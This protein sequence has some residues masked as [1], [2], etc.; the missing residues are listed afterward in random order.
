MA[1]ASGHPAWALETLDRQ[2]AQDVTPVVFEQ[3]DLEL[4]VERVK[5]QIATVNEAVAKIKEAEKLQARADEARAS[6][7]K[8]LRP[9]I[10]TAATILDGS[11]AI[12][13]PEYKRR[14]VT[15]GD[16]LVTESEAAVNL[17]ALHPYTASSHNPVRTTIEASRKLQK[18]VR[19]TGKNLEAFFTEN[20]AR[21]SAHNE[22]RAWILRA[23][24][25]DEVRKVTLSHLS[26]RDLYTIERTCKD[27][28]N[29]CRQERSRIVSSIPCIS[30]MELKNPKVTLPKDLLATFYGSDR[31]VVYSLQRTSDSS[32]IRVLR[33]KLSIH[34][35][36][37]DEWT[38]LPQLLCIPGTTTSESGYAIGC[39][40][41]TESGEEV[42]FV[43]LRVLS[44]TQK[45]DEDE[46]EGSGTWLFY[47]RNGSWHS[48]R[49][50]F[51]VSYLLGTSAVAV[52][53]KLV[54]AT[55]SLYH[56]EA[57]SF[58]LDRYQWQKLPDLQNAIHSDNGIHEA[59]YYKDVRCLKHKNSI[60]IVCLM[61]ETHDKMDSEI[62]LI[63]GLQSEENDDDTYTQLHF[64]CKSSAQYCRV[65][66]FQHYI[67]FFK[68]DEATA[69]YDLTCKKLYTR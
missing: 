6:A 60:I 13:P 5:S 12:L 39:T 11:R 20:A 42:V 58:V 32:K 15:S 69:L 55:K 26:L 66:V 21:S 29:W 64:M 7:I 27:M 63:Q 23:L 36:A 59:K 40:F 25:I 2:L 62:D 54:I 1:R 56:G 53:N 33:C 19:R 10:R 34:S 8:L 57:Y 67:V 46:D 22:E 28:R 17:L 14:I 31:R 49:C 16:K 45:E 68:D 61:E 37:H 65:F 3:P 44:Q 35:R 47:L 41:I 38:T 51:A 52:H 24:G 4:H 48:V 30:F 43:C 50:P 18:A 9:A